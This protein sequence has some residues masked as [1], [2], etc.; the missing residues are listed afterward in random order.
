MSVQFCRLG[1]VEYA[2][3]ED[4]Q[5]DFSD[6]RIRDE[7]PDTV[8]FLEHPPMYTHGKQDVKRDFRRDAPWIRSHG[9]RVVE[10]DR[11]GRL[12]YH[13]PGQVVGYLILKLDGARR[14]VP[15]LVHAIEEALI[16]ALAAWTIHGLRDSDYPGVWVQEKSVGTDGETK[17]AKIAAI[18]L[19]VSRGVTRHGFALNVSPDLSHYEGI[20]PC[21]IADRGVTSM[22][23]ILESRGDRRPDQEEVMDHLEAALKRTLAP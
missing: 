16:D 23:A 13:G 8:L 22:R 19:H 10:T 9:I 2:V 3:T 1:R 14:R 15:C 18:G 17:P 6:R 21:G 12:T 11:G 20:V 7:I 5:R 4:L